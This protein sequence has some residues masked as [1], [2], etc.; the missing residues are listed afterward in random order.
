MSSIGLFDRDFLDRSDGVRYNLQLMKLAAYHRRKRDM[1]SFITDPTRA[2]YYT[3][4][5]Y[6][7]NDPELSFPKELSSRDNV[8]IGGY[9]IN[10]VYEPLFPEAENILPATD[11]YDAATSRLKLNG[12]QQEQLKSQNATHLQLTADGST[13]SAF[14]W[15]QARARKHLG[16]I[17]HII[18]HDINIA[19]YESQIP[20]FVKVYM[21]QIDN[22]CNYSLL[23]QYPL[24][25]KKETALELTKWGIAAWSAQ[26]FVDGYLNGREA[27]KFYS[28]SYLSYAGTQRVVFQLPEAKTY[29]SQCALFARS[30]EDTIWA[31]VHSKYYNFNA[32]SFSPG[33]DMLFYQ[34]PYWTQYNVSHKQALSYKDY[35]WKDI[36]EGFSKAIVAWRELE[37][38][39]RG[40]PSIPFLATV[41]P[42]DV[43]ERKIFL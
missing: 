29:R 26:I 20:E 31:Q 10:P 14:S 41:S 2:P 28:A 34:L 11:I 19:P 42:K 17:R 8:D 13:I 30:L 39:E 24:I 9:A 33:L 38:V 35:L 15:E 36:Q 23:F 4:I 1:V 12:I 3:K 16:Q 27:K 7:Q 40:D 43:K 37:K 6:R 32:P 21:D 5:Y 18:L 25:M 22:N